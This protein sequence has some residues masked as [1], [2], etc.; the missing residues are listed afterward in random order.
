MDELGSWLSRQAGAVR[1]DR[2]QNGQ[3]RQLAEQ[4]G[5][6]GQ[7]GQAAEWTGEAVG[8][9]DRQVRSGR[10]GNRVDR[11]GSWLSRQAGGVRKDRQQSGQ[12]RQLAVQTGRW[13][14][15]GQEAEWTGEA[16]GCADRQVRSGKTRN[17]VD[18]G[19]SWLSR[20]AGTVRK[21]RKQ[22]GQERELAELTGRCGQEGQAAEWT[23]EAV[24]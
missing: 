19:E 16:V 6:W 4:T 12:A 20:Q 24:G 9:A 23:G 21:D 2:Q 14:Q 18:R 13:G 17:R 8:C 7:E 10:T 11:R 5:R 22:S 3:A 1:K 15:E